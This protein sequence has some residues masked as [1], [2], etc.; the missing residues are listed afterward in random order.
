MPTVNV[1]VSSGGSVLS[2]G[3]GDGGMHSLYLGDVLMPIAPAKMTVKV[4]NKNT[5]I[6]LASGGVYKVLNPPGLTGYEFELIIPH[7]S[8][9]LPFA[10]YEDGYKPPQYFFDHFEKLKGAKDLADGVFPFI[11]VDNSNT[12]TLISTKCTLEEY[13]ISQDA[14]E[15]ILDYRV[16]MTLERYDEHVT[17]SFVV[18]QDEDGS[19]VA[20]DESTHNAL[21]A[22]ADAMNA[23]Q[24]A[25]NMS[26]GAADLMA[27]Y[28][29]ETAMKMAQACATMMGNYATVKDARDLAEKNGLNPCDTILAG[30]VIKS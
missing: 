21:Q 20:I 29:T 13:E 26:Q 14:D 4:I 12:P 23:A 11:F 17:Q 8:S 18:V 24:N 16:Q 7:D 2:G 15:D 30:T 10:I 1:S 19:W 6:D 22:A 3:T 28:K 25:V 9:S 5:T 27:Q